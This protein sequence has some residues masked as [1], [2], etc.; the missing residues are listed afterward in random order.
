V[1]G[2]EKG[3]GN[4]ALETPGATWERGPGQG[5]GTGGDD[6]RSAPAR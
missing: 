3:P 2:T 4:R 6:R 1:R 5:L